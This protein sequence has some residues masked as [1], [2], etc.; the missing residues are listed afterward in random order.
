MIDIC[1]WPN[2]EKNFENYEAESTILYIDSGCDLNHPEIYKNII[3]NECKSFVRGDES[4]TDFTGHGTQIISAIT[5]RNLIRGLNKESKIIVYKITDKYGN[6]KFEWLF[7]ALRTAIEK[8]YRVI[9]ISYTGLT[10]DNQIIESFQKLIDKAVENN[11][12]ICCSANNIIHRDTDF[13]IPLDLKGVHKVGS[14]NYKNEVSI[15]NMNNKDI[16]FYCPG[17]DDIFITNTTKSL[18][19]L[20]NSPQSTFNIGAELGLDKKY[21]LNYGNSIASS[22]FSCSMSLLIHYLESKNKIER[23]NGFYSNILKNNKEINIIK[24]VKGE[25]MRG[26][27]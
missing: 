4:L 3:T 22:F 10:K 11:I 14:L 18:I 13:I 5:G 7:E 2:K 27:F 17:G 19:L 25:I 6:S 8:H 26:C 24:K 21:T 16:D 23:N 9:N 12:H 15:F 1:N 20:A